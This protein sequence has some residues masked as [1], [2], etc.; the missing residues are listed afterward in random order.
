MNNVYDVYGIRVTYP[1]RFRVFIN[2]REPFT[3]KSGMVKFDDTQGPDNGRISLSVSWEEADVE[4]AGRFASDYLANAAEHYEKKVK[5]R[6]RILDSGISD[7][8][9]TP[10]AFLHSILATRTH[11]MKF[12]G[13]D[14]TLEIMQTARYH[15]ETGRVVIATVM[16][17]SSVF[18]TCGSGLRRMLSDISVR[19][20]DE[21]AQETDYLAADAAE[22]EAP[23][24]DGGAESVG[25][26]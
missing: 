4:D 14:F 7:S 19:G 18:K 1:E 12:A 20:M 22:G 26:A 9:G 8:D 5:N 16:A 24:L 6:Y 23:V 15:K 17:D 2:Q 25:A 21:K 13:K 10:T 3:F 11:V